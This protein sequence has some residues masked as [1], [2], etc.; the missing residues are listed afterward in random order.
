M[1][2]ILGLIVSL[3]QNSLAAPDELVFGIL[4]DGDTSAEQ[5]RID[6][7]IQSIEALEAHFGPEVQLRIL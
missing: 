7:Y 2:T 4:R 6:L 5:Q 3:S 1:N